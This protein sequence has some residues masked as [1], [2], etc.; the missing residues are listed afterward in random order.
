[1]KSSL[2][3]VALIL[4]LLIAVAGCTKDSTTT[5]PV[6]SSSTGSSISGI[7][8]VI[9]GSSTTK[10]M[11]FRDDNL[12]YYMNQYSYG[13]KD[14]M[15]GV[16]QVSGST[17]DFGNGQSPS[18]YSF[19]IKNDTLTMTAPQANTIVA[20]RNPAAPSD[21]AWAKIVAVQDSIPAPIPTPT[22]MTVKGTTLIYGDAYSSHHL[23]KI[24]LVSKAV[25]SSMNT[26]VYAWAVEW[27]GTNLWASS[28]GY[29]AIYKLDSTGA[30]LSNSPAMG[31]WIYGI[32]WDGTVFWCSSN[33]ESSIYR[34]N[35][36][37]N[38]VVSTLP[39]TDARPEGLAYA[40]G[41]VYVCING[42]INKCS[43]SPFNTVSSYRIPNASAFGI[44]FDGANFWVSCDMGNS[45]K[46][47]KVA[48]P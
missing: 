23:Y 3:L 16:Y 29:D 1:M 5:A 21:T 41:Y 13:L 14:F 46:I 27:D 38:T 31:A 43:T 9:S 17:V 18:L 40:G 42:V 12:Y 15:V 28:D 10:H 48:L 39:I 37:S 34:Y 44:A 4:L 11:E 22:D 32:A 33:N 24:D 35:P 19:T 30:T 7:W 8:T 36:T 25:D 20:F 26:N 45:A 2:G 47:Y 6:T